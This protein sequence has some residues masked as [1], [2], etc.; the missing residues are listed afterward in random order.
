MCAGGACLCALVV[1]G[2]VSSGSVLRGLPPRPPR[3]AQL[4]CGVGVKPE[5]APWAN[6]QPGGRRSCGLAVRSL[7]REVAC[8]TPHRPPWRSH[9]GTGWAPLGG[10]GLL[11]VTT[12]PCSPF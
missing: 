6:T 11:G 2:M 9:H 8:P 1:C 3:G 12:L 10:G 5:G 7:G 4:H